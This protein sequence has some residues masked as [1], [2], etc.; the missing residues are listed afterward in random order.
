MGEESRSRG[1]PTSLPPLAK[2]LAP[3]RRPSDELPG[4]PLADGPESPAGA[5]QQA[6]LRELED[7]VVVIRERLD[8]EKAGGQLAGD[9]GALTEPVLHVDPLKG[10]RARA[11]LGSDQADGKGVRLARR[12]GD[13]LALVVA[14][15][16][17]VRSGLGHQLV[18]RL[19]E[20]SRAEEQQGP[21]RTWPIGPSRLPRA[22]LTFA[23]LVT[24]PR[25]ELGLVP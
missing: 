11:E 13:E 4:E 9:L 8:Q 21:D 23:L 1:S 12:E 24:P 17:E 14:E 19:L 10:R 25:I 16:R 6:R 7:D 5:P 22:N 20:H 2:R 18:E 15:D 3:R